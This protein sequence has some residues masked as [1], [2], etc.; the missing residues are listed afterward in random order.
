[1]TPTK[2]AAAPGG[3]PGFSPG[4]SVSWET[5][6][7]L[8]NQSGWHPDPSRACYPCTIESRNGGLLPSH[9]MLRDCVPGS[10]IPTAEMQDGG[11]VA[12][13]LCGK[14]IRGFSLF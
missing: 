14:E 1:M 8:T 5:P 4:S 11:D 12:S 9:K 2:D 10:S 3:F 7:S 13:H 6:W